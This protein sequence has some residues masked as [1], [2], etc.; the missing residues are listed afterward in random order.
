[1]NQLEKTFPPSWVRKL[2]K[3]VT[4]TKSPLMGS[5]FPPES[6]LSWF[7]AQHLARTANGTICIDPG[8]NY[9]V[10]IGLAIET[11]QNEQ[12]IDKLITKLCKNPGIQHHLC[13]AAELQGKGY[14][15]SLEPSTGSGN[16]TNDILARINDREYGIEVKELISNNPKL[17]LL[18]EIKDKAKKSPLEP[19]HPIIFHVVLSEKRGGKNDHIKTKEFID[20]IGDISDDMP[21]N[22]S[23]VVI[24][25]RQIDPTGGKVKREVA[26]IVLNSKANK[27]SIE[28]DLRE[29]FKSNFKKILYPYLE[30]GTLFYVDNSGKGSPD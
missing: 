13:L 1:M 9:L 10:E 12:K 14:L 5:H 24:G 2:Y 3:D 29:L 27:P 4:D 20:K 22:I 16:A 11:L 15:H 25:R 19:T 28:K 21:Q 7:P 8:W 30:I 18:Q 6:S 26:E 17:K 23:A